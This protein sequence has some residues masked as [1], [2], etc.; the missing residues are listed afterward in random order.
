MCPLFKGSPLARRCVYVHSCVL[1]HGVTDV[2]IRKQSPQMQIVLSN[3]E[4]HVH[5]YYHHMVVYF[6]IKWFFLVRQ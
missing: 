5:H 4:T 2:V 1:Q 3:F 6:V